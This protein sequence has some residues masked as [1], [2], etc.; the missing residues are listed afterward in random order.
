MTF[1][2]EEY[3]EIYESNQEKEIIK[4]YDLNQELVLD[5]NEDEY[6]IYLRDLDT[7]EEITRFPYGQREGSQGYSFVVSPR[8]NYLI[9]KELE[10]GVSVETLYA[11][12]YCLKDINSE[13]PKYVEELGAP[14]DPFFRSHSHLSFFFNDGDNEKTIWVQGQTNGD[15]EL[16]DVYSFGGTKA[17]KHNSKNLYAQFYK[18][19][20]YPSVEL[21]TEIRDHRQ[22][23]YLRP[24]MVVNTLEDMSPSPFEELEPLPLTH[25]T[26]PLINFLKE[27]Q[28]EA[29]SLTHI[30]VLDTNFSSLPGKLR[31]ELD[32][33][34]FSY[35]IITCEV[36]AVLEKPSRF[37]F[38]ISTP[39]TI[40]GAA[41]VQAISLLNRIAKETDAIYEGYTC[42]HLSNYTETDMQMNSF[43]LYEELAKGCLARKIKI[44]ELTEL[45][46]TLSDKHKVL[47]ISEIF[48]GQQQTLLSDVKQCL[49]DFSYY[50]ASEEEVEYALKL[51]IDMKRTKEK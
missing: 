31:I 10:E 41:E 26:Q 22:S 30:I 8:H 1:K 44:E 29:R 20:S 35:E 2:Y 4:L 16:I 34:C 3:I 23:I 47:G 13:K 33:H 32:R 48:S 9:I 7:G 43:K 40:D 19:A 37:Y 36:S 38:L 50:E 17:D 27:Q 28:P 21:E 51:L 14:S 11:T 42:R 49:N 6:H 39:L 5:F 25:S 24:R 46:N 18:I 45:I 15:L 12:V